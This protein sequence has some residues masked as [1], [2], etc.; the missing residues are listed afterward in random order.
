MLC[1]CTQKCTFLCWQ[2]STCITYT[3]Y[4]CADTVAPNEQVRCHVLYVYFREH[5]SILSEMYLGVIDSL[6]ACR[7]LDGR[8]DMVS[9]GIKLSQFS[10]T[11]PKPGPGIQ[12]RVFQSSAGSKKP[13]KPCLSSTP[14]I[15]FPAH[16][17]PL[18]PIPLAVV[19]PMGGVPQLQAPEIFPPPGTILREQTPISS[20]SSTSQANG[21]SLY[22][23]MSGVP[24]LPY[25]FGAPW[26]VCPIYPP[27]MSQLHHHFGSQQLLPLLSPPHPLPPFLSTSW[28]REAALPPV[29]PFCNS[30][31]RLDSPPK[32]P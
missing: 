18:F 20:P 14:A 32:Q 3:S 13:K 2:T 6:V 19:D 15:Q 21:D 12:K 10:F 29:M 30:S 4:V 26:L 7:F 5:F 17:P 25:P 24:C 23:G 1:F 9:K 28:G 8:P 22:G 27:N 16:Y 31:T 11:R